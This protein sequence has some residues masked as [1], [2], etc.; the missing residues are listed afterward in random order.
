MKL[1]FLCCVMQLGVICQH[2]CKQQ[3]PASPV[4]AR[5]ARLVISARRRDHVCCQKMFNA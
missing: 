2:H 3:Q 1:D 4:N 5:L